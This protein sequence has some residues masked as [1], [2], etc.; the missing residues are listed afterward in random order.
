MSGFWLLL[1]AVLGAEPAAGPDRLVRLQREGLELGLWPEAG[2]RIVWLRPAGGPN[3]LAANAAAWAPGQAV[4]EPRPDSP[5]TEFGGHVTWVGPQSAWWTQ[6]DLNQDRRSRA[7][8]WPPDPWLDLGRCEW[9]ER[10]PASAVLVGPASPV[11]GLQMT[12][13]VRLLGGGRVALS[14][15]GENRGTRPVAWNL[16]SVTRVPATAVLLPLAP[17]QPLRLQFASATPGRE[18]PPAYT[19]VADRW[20]AIAARDLPPGAA[21]VSGKF[22]TTADP[23]LLAAFVGDWLLLKRGAAVAPG[24]VPREHA[25]VEVFVT[26]PADPAAALC[27]LELHGPYRT[28]PPGASLELREEWVL[29]RCPAGLGAAGR[30]QVLQELLATLPAFGEALADE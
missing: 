30:V 15:R 9:R 6:Q 29:R 25:P 2:G 24:E 26:R 21:A 28:L 12:Y 5:S 7:A 23:P 19:I 8:I 18:L 20:L 27:E 1:A 11:S 22:A 3:L 16:W 13:R 17:G 14:A 4:P 10:S